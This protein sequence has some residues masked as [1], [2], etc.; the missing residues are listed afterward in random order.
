MTERRQRPIPVTTQERA[1]LEEQK[2]RYEQRSGDT[3]DWG[4]FLGTIT[5]LGLAAAGVYTLAK[6]TARSRQSVDVECTECGEM[7]VMAVPN[8][9]DRA[10]YTTCPHCGN[11]LVV[12]LEVT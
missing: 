7:F 1:F 6:A 4:K 2:S 11:E 3:G 12:Y 8:R 5:L 9:V 10:T